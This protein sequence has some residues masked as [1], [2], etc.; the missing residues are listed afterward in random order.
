[1]VLMDDPWSLQ[2]MDIEEDLDAALER[3]IITNKEHLELQLS[4]EKCIKSTR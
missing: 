2:Q 1:M 4:L 3:K